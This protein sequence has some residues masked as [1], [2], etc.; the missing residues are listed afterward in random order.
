MSE[1]DEYAQGH[2]NAALQLQ[3]ALANQNPVHTAA[4]H[5]ADESV[6]RLVYGLSPCCRTGA[7][8]A[9]DA[10]SRLKIGIT[11]TCPLAGGFDAWRNANLSVSMG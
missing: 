10:N 4:A 8:A 2:V 7:R 5:G 9:R 3:R 6:T 1:H 11:C